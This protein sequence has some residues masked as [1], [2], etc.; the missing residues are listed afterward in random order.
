MIASISCSVRLVYAFLLLTMPPR[1][2]VEAKTPSMASGKITSTSVKDNSDSQ[3]Q[4]GSVGSGSYDSSV[5]DGE[6]GAKHI[7]HFSDTHLNISANLDTN[8]SAEIPIQYGYDAPISLLNSALKY[9]KQILPNPD[10]FLY[11]GDHAVHGDPS[12]EYLAE[13]V[14]T[15]VET[16][17]Q[18]FSGSG[19]ETNNA[20][21]ILGDTDVKSYRVSSLGRFAQRIQYQGPQ[22]PW[23]LVV[24]DYR[25]SPSTYTEHG[26]VLGRSLFASLSGVIQCLILWTLQPKHTP[27][28]TNETDP[29]AQFA[30]LNATLSGLRNGGKYAY[31]AGHIPPIIDARDGSPMWEASYIAQYK[32]IVTQYADVIKAQIFGHTHS[33]EFRLP[34]TDDMESQDPDE[35]IAAENE[36]Q[37]SQLVPLFMS[38]AISPIFYNN[39]AF[40]V[41]DLDPSTY[42]LLDFSV[43]GT[44]I[45]GDNRSDLSWQLLFKASSAYNVSSLSWSEMNRFI[46]AGATNS[47]LVQQYYYNSQAQSYQQTSCEDSVCL[48]WYLCSMLW[49]T[50]PEDFTSCLAADSRLESSSAAT[51]APASL[52]ALLILPA[53]EPP[54]ARQIVS[55]ND[56]GTN[57]ELDEA[58]LR[59]I[60]HQVPEDMK[61][62]IFSVVGAF[63]TGKSFA[64]DLFLRYLRHASRGR[65][66]KRD[67]ADDEAAE[68]WK[69]WVLE[70]VGGSEAKLEG[71]SN[72]A[73]THGEKGFSWRAGRK[74]NTTG[75]WMWETP[76]IRPSQTGEDIAVFLI[77]TQGMFDSE[78]SQMLTAS[79]FGLSTLLSSYQ[80]YNVDKRVQEDNLQHLALFTEYGR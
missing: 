55:I 51:S 8:E 26:A 17:A 54:R 72:V 29:F 32:K 12:D 16:M 68:V 56:E 69:A 2:D 11:T 66:L 33:V 61:V 63:R 20:T 77:D 59:H 31:I 39:P 10:I 1:L 73:Q 44:N 60:F 74:R 28:T 30:W 78:T 53:K 71:N 19:N 70:G 34:L 80:I 14:K 9:A 25:E 45:S 40:M 18:Y 3:E 23:L 7:L 67:G 79:I 52:P 49:W 57:F 64:L 46:V 38:S 41:W 22:H 35:V 13:A 37:S 75:I 50:T 42:D 6:V 43:Y 4:A 27:D 48:T 5:G 15:N 47:T 58:A 65:M 24:Q 62:A 36:D 76:F 21:A